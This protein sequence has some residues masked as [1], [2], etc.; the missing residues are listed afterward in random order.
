M[1]GTYVGCIDQPIKKKRATG[2]KDHVRTAGNAEEKVD[3][4][5]KHLS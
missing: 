3:L 5:S 1:D 4:I 2:A